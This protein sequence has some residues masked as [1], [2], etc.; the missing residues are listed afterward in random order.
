MDKINYPSKWCG[1][2]ESSSR[3]SANLVSVSLETNGKGYIGYI[4][5]LPG[6]FIRGKT[7]EEAISKVDREVQSYLKWL[8]IEREGDYKTFVFL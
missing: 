4:V 7:E 3:A 2:F 8:G 5:E 1:M 6:A